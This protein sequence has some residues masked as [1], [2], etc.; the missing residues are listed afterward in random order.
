MR[1]PAFIKFF[2]GEI[3]KFHHEV[4]AG[5][6]VQLLAPMEKQRLLID[7]IIDEWGPKSEV[8]ITKIRNKLDLTDEGHK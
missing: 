8:R 4:G 2:A 3:F 6:L 1:N 5:A 7:I